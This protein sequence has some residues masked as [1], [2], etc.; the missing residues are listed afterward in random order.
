M[1]PV[2]ID[3]FHV[4]EDAD[5]GSISRTVYQGVEPPDKWLSTLYSKPQVSA[6]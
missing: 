3:V 1:G 6:D 5:T 4:R 2:Q